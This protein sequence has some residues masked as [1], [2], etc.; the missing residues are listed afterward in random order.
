MEV[1]LGKSSAKGGFSI[2]MIAMFD[3]KIVLYI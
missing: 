3:L 2:A 1:V